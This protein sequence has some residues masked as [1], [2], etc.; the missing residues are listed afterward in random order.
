[1]AEYEKTASESLRERRF[2]SSVIEFA[3]SR[4]E[5]P[6]FRADDSDLRQPLAFGYF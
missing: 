5:I 1:M 6:G 4:F 2:P 3:G